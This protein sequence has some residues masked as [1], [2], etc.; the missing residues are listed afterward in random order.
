MRQAGTEAVADFAARVT[1]LCSRTYPKFSSE[2][3]LDLAV[4]YFISGLANV[5]SHEFLRRERARRHINWQEAVQMA[6]AFEPPP[7]LDHVAAIA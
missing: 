7:A 3:Q 6:Q 1:D 2:D 4:Y 5:T